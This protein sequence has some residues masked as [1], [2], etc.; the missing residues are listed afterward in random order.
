MAAKIYDRNHDRTRLCLHC[1]SPVLDKPTRTTVSSWRGPLS[2]G[3]AA[4]P[5]VTVSYKLVVRLYMVVLVARTDR[6]PAPP[7]DCGVW[8]S[9]AHGSAHR[10]VGPAHSA[11]RRRG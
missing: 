4:L 6:D 1:E 7:D 9:G 11:A 3:G 8:G 10:S 5:S 2:M